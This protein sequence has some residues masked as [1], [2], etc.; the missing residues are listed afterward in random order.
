MTP[1]KITLHSSNSVQ[2]SE[3]VLEAIALNTAAGYGSEVTIRPVKNQRTSQQQKSIEVY[4]GQ[5]AKAMNEGGFDQLA[6]HEF[7]HKKGF[8]VPNTQESVKETLW[9]FVQKFMFKK[10]SSTQLE[11]HEVSKV[12]EVVNRGTAEGFGISIPFP[13]RFT[14]AE[15]RN[16]A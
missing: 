5:L 16:A 12:Y 1:E 14:Q 13:D 8:G 7:L 2:L 10:K 4:C 9:K 6:V 15:Q 3:E 11:T